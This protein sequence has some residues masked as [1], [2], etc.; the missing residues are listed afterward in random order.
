MIVTS[1]KIEALADEAASIVNKAT[2]HWGT[3]QGTAA[4][5]FAAEVFKALYEQ[6]KLK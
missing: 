5:V 6:E 4:G 2:Y 3:T 1:A